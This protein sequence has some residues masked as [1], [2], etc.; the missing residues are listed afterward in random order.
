MRIARIPLD[1]ATSFATRT[2]SARDYLPGQA[3]Q[4]WQSVLHNAPGLGFNFD[5]K[6][7]KK[8]ALDRSRTWTVVK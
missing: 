1:H 4:G 5:E 7:V 6:A 2:V 3:A 8:Y